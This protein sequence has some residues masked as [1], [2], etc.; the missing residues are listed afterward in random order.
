VLAL[1]VERA[2]A[3]LFENRWRL[4]RFDDKLSKAPFV[5]LVAPWI[6]IASMMALG[7]GAPGPAAE[8]APAGTQWRMVVFQVDTSAA[9]ELPPATPASPKG[10]II[11]SLQIE[12]AQETLER[13]FLLHVRVRNVSQS[14]RSLRWDVTRSPYLR[15]PDGRKVMPIGHKLA[16]LSAASIAVGGVLEV[17]LLPNAIFTLYPVF[18]PDPR[19]R[20]ALL[21]IDGVG[22]RRMR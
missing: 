15:L 2:P 13:A 22:R 18:A 17:D 9:V 3:P 10:R 19:F 14:V 20:D 11:K 7:P 5:F 12:G 8:P 21:V 6:S 4:A 1:A 16:G